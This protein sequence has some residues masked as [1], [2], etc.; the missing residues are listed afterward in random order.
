MM[1]PDTLILCI[2]KAAPFYSQFQ[3]AKK[4]RNID[5]YMCIYIYIYNIGKIYTYICIYTYL[6]VGKGEEGHVNLNSHHIT[7]N[8]PD[9]NKEENK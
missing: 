3:Q 9:I 7:P 4:Q 8:E 6:G 1:L 5:T 2:L